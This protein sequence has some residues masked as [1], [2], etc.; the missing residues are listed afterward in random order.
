MADLIAWLRER[1]YYADQIVEHRRLPG[2]EPAFADTTVESRLAGALAD[3][4]VD[5]LYRHQAEAIEAVRDGDDVVLATPTA[6]GKSLAYAVPAFERAMDHGGRT[7]YLGPQ[8]A[9][10]ADQEQSL[11]SLARGLGFGSRV[12]VAQYTGRL[13]KTEKRDVRDRRPTVL[14]SNP[15]MLHYGLLPHAHRLWEW[16]V[17]SLETIV[18][19]EVHEYRG[20][21]GS[22]VALTLR[23]LRRV[24][25]RFD[26][27]PQFIC[28]SATIGN[29]RE[30]AARVTG[31]PA[32][33]FRLIDEDTAGTGPTHW[34]LWNPPEYA[35]GLDRSG[36]RRSSHVETKRLFVDL[37]SRGYQTLV[38]TRAR[39]AAER[40]ATESAET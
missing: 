34:V 33:G 30:H 5:R 32:E 31:K 4:G 26:S 23:R 40:Y 37:V 39:Q 12:S 22:H 27:D 18:L 9:L 6:S 38:F 10:I 16:L 21:F 8:N 19:D 25:E 14:L 29:P 17:G 20:V 2:R 3:R 36:R 35:D 1:P 24:C 13:S 28:C 11:S 7:L 15:D